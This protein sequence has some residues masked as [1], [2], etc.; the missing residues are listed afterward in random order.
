LVAAA[1]TIIT[2]LET[3]IERVKTELPAWQA[4]R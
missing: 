4:K 1:G 2:A 3:D